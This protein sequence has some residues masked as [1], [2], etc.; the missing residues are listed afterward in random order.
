MIL[1]NPFCHPLSQEPL[2]CRILQFKTVVKCIIKGL[3]WHSGNDRQVYCQPNFPLEKKFVLPLNKNT[4]KEHLKALEKYEDSQCWTKFWM[5][6][7]LT[8]M[9]LIF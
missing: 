3:V 4:K 7:K 5:E 8:E 6:G 2:F 9:S 1:Q